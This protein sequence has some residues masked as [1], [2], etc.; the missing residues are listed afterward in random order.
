[1]DKTVIEK[2]KTNIFNG[3]TDVLLVQEEIT[4][5]IGHSVEATKMIAPRRAISQYVSIF[6]C[7][8]LICGNSNIDRVIPTNVKPLITIVQIII[9]NEYYGPFVL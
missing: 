2:N 4:W 3:L 9:T 1:M 7:L 5:S 8:I 6:M